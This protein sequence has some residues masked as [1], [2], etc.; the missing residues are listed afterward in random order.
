[1][2]L[3]GESIEGLLNLFSLEACVIFDVKELV[4]IE[5]FASVF[6]INLFVD[7]FVCVKQPFETIHYDHHF[8]KPFA[9][10]HAKTLLFGVTCA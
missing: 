6:R 8:D 4:G 2:V 5:N 3:V 10:A 9:I 1:M 7:Q